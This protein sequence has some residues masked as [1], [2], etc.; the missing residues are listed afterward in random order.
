MVN[1]WSVLGSPELGA[2]SCVQA[3][4]KT[5]KGQ[6]SASRERVDGQMRQALEHQESN[7]VKS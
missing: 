1:D 5:N 6:L 3:A 7:S 2:K 4:P